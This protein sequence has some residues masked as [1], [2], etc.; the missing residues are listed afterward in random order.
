[1]KYNT[2]ATKEI[3]DETIKNLATNGIEGIFVET[4]KDALAKIKEL[5]PAG[6]SVMN[7]ASVTLEQIGFVDYLKGETHGWNNLHKG[8]I[9]EK[10]T[11]KQMILRK[12][13]VL[14][15]YYLGSVHALSQTGDFIVASNSG[16]QL[17]H[18]IYTSPN[19]IFVV[20]AQKLVPN[21]DEAMKRLN[22]YVIPLEDDHMME[23][24][25][26]HTYP[27]KILIF[28]KESAYLQRKVR[29]I[30]VNESLGF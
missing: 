29:M 25:K 10:D 22:E 9:D 18:V 8:I 13:A 24:M 15:D 19:V 23:K 1:M 6:A 30:I 27:S 11:A 12:H 3:I 21:L 14:S 4:G 26:I 2:L 7:G 5:I 17:P 28:K 16:S 20:G